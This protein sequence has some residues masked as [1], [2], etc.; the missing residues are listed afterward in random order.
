MYAGASEAAYCPHELSY[1]GASEAV[2]TEAD[3]TY[4]RFVSLRV[5]RKSLLRDELS[6]CV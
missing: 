4:R 6:L 3:P 5:M 2:Q 1:A